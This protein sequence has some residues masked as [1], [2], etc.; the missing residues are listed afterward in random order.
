MAGMGDWQGVI[1][2]LSKNDP[3]LVH[4]DLRYCN[5][6]DSGTSKLAQ[7]FCFLFFVFCFLFFVFC[8]LFCLV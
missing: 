7:V 8:F 4:V 2:K 5:L 3:T 6:G 1:K